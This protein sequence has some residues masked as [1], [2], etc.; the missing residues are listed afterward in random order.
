[1]VVCDWVAVSCYR[2]RGV[3]SAAQPGAGDLEGDLFSAVREHAESMIGWA[4]SEE[5]LGLEHHELEQCAM[6]DGMELM[7]LLAHLHLRALR[8]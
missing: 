6:T 8:E 7:G 4:R 1:M 2:V 5:A 3:G